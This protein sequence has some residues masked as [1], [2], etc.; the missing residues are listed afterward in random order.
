[1]EENL[2]DAVVMNTEVE[3]ATNSDETSYEES[4]SSSEV[5]ALRKA[6]AEIAARAR[7]AEAEVKKLKQSPQPQPI[8]NQLSEELK[9]IARGLSD[10]EIEKAKIIAKGLG[11]NLQDALKNDLFISFQKDMKEK[12]ARED[13]KLGASKGSGEYVEDEVIKPTMTREEHMAAFNKLN[14]K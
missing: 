6:N 5:E 7:R 14:G 13:A 9:L 2:D 8:N 1:M 4:S 11:T 3:E 12:Q 10:E